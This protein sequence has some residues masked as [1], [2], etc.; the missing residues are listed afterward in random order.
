MTS[1]PVLAMLYRMRFLSPF[2]GLLA[3]LQVSF[4]G[5]PA[6]AA[7]A[8]QDEIMEHANEPW[9]GDLDGITERR[10]LRI[11]T[12]HNPLF[13]SFDGARQKGMVAGLAKVFVISAGRY[14]LPIY[15]C[16]IL[17]IPSWKPGASRLPSAWHDIVAVCE[18]YELLRCDRMF[19][20][21]TAQMLAN[22]RS[23]DRDKVATDAHSIAD[24]SRC[25]CR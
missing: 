17:S 4:T 1:Q 16:P 25:A 5:S 7:S 18:K 20:E 12:V 14:R 22:H 3:L 13:F 19:L 23:G 10:F 6:L 8:Q 2:I 11:Q 9:S 21:V 15:R 24:C